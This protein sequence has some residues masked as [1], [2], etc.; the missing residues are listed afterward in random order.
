MEMK[1]QLY[2]NEAKLLRKIIFNKNSFLL[3]A[4]KEKRQ[5][6]SN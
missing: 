1:N 5:R 2:S 4:L 3:Y 6:K